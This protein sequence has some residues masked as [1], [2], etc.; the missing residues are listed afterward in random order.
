MFH[1]SNIRLPVQWERS[2]PHPCHTPHA[3][4]SPLDQTRRDNQQ[5]VERLDSLGLAHGSTL[6]LAVSQD[7]IEIGIPAFS[8]TAAV[9]LERLLIMP[10]CP[11]PDYWRFP[12]TAKQER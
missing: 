8:G 12:D 6:R 4:N 9:R 11:Q 2:Q 7:D 3:R 5:L 10:F 1:H